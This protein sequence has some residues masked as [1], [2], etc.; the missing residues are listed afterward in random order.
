MH[1]TLVSAA[2]QMNF[3]GNETAHAFGHEDCRVGS[4]RRYLSNKKFAE[5]RREIWFWCIQYIKDRINV[6]P[7]RQEE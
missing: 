4:E 1:R 2:G 5:Q 7:A 6:A 3:L